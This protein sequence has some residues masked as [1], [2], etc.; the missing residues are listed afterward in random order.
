MSF[1]SKHARSF[2]RAT[3]VSVI[4]TG[5][6]FLLLPLLVRLLHVEHWV[7]YAAVQFVGTAITFLLSRYWA[8]EARHAAEL[9]TQG[10][11][12]L[13]VF[14][15]SFVLNTALPSVGS[16]LLKLPPELAFAIAQGLVYL[17]WNYPL[18]KY[19]VFRHPDPAAD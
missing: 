13:A 10:I 4:A 17:A 9:H 7:A 14:G 18:N 8:F 2:T 12:Y 11:R 5:T 19:W 6:E 15:G 16:Y 3:M 1:F